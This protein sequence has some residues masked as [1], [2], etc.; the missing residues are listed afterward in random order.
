MS[1]PV[2]PLILVISGA[3]F[4]GKAILDALAQAGKWASEKQARSELQH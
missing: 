3:G 4:T 1:S 2:K